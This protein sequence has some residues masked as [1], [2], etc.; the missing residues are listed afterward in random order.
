MVEQTGSV[1]L[2]IGITGGFGGAVA[3]A[4]QRHGM[5]VRAL[6]RDPQTARRRLA[7]HGLDAA[8]VEL[9]RGDAG[10]RAAVIDAAKGVAVIVHGGNPPKY[11]NW[12]GLAL[13]MLG[14]VIAAAEAS[15]ARVVFPGNLYIYDPTQGPVVDEGAPSL[16]GT[17]KGAI[18][19][20]ME[21][22]LA[23]AGRRGVRSLTVRAGDFFGPGASEGWFAAM[24]KRGKAGV[25]AVVDPGRTGHSWA[26]LPD[27][28]ETVAR[29]LAHD[30]P[31][32]AVFHFRG[33][34]VDPGV[35]AAAIAT[36]SPGS[37]SVKPF[38]WLLFRLVAPFVR[39]FGEIA[40]VAWLWKVPM[41]LD[42]QRL[43]AVIGVEPHTELRH[44]VTATLAAMTL[45]TV[46][47]R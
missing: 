2:V 7:V 32:R 37:V 12:R 24:L 8:S 3:A 47:A 39:L 38:S 11:R 19:R 31:T 18:R 26:Y 29:L 17:K 46:A 42:N 40:E 35:M 13:P 5:G 45:Q 41:R 30:L 9:V 1:A 10:D 16:T 22:M 21:A 44:A 27:I 43:E 28:G 20:E 34:W 36:A 14:N 6:V 25:T 23:D 15:G 33:H 4:L